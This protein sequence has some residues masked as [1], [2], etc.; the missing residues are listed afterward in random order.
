MNYKDN[1]IDNWP[2]TW[3]FIPDDIKPG[4][5]LINI[6]KPFIK[7]LKSCKL[8]SKTINEHI[9]NLWLLGGHIIKQ[10]NINPDFREIDQLLL[11][12][13]YID[14]MDGPSMQDLSE[15][16]QESFDKTCRKFYKY[17]IENDLMRLLSK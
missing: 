7:Y 5:G 13:R 17:L 15:Y 4:I 1:D 10:S 16:E 2:K 3:A 6:F 11:L 8:S 12:P 9:D 14:S